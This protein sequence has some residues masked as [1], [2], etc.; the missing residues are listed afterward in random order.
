MAESKCSELH[1]AKVGIGGDVVQEGVGAVVQIDLAAVVFQTVAHDQIFHFQDHV[2]SANLVE[3]YLGDLH[4]W[5]F[6]LHNHQGLQPLL[7]IHHR[8][9]S[10]THAVQRHSHLICHQRGGVALLRYQE[11]HKML[12]H[13]LLGGEGDKLVAKYILYLHHPVHFFDVR[14]EGWQIQW[15]HLGCIWKQR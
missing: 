11:V 6:V 15:L 9:A 13:P 2:V 12:A 7:T 8:V 14:F 10:A 1:F 3:Y 4:V 5:T